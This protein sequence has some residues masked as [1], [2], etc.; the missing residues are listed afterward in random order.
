MR[1]EELGSDFPRTS[2]MSYLTTS[3]HNVHS[4]YMF[5]Q[6]RQCEELSTLTAP[7]SQTYLFFGLGNLTSISLHTVALHFFSWISSA[8]ST[9]SPR[10]IIVIL[11]LTIAMCL[12]SSDHRPTPCLKDN[13]VNWDKWLS[14]RLWSFL[15]FQLEFL[16][17]IL[18]LTHSPSQVHRCIGLLTCYRGEIYIAKLERK[19]VENLTNIIKMVLVLRV[20]TLNPILRIVLRRVSAYFPK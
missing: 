13:V 2:S 10:D 14:N 19:S 1:S 17:W 12:K 11:D 8:V 4:K 20:M 18:C 3:L 6:R 15:A 9:P 7:Y 5:K 16:I